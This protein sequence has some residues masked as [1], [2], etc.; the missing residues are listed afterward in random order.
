MKKIIITFLLALG[1]LYSNAQFPQPIT[2]GGSNAMTTNQGAFKSKKVLILPTIDTVHAYAQFTGALTYR[3]SNGLL[4][5]A[6]GTY[7]ELV[8]RDLIVTFP[9][10]ARGDTIVNRAAPGSVLYAGGDSNITSF[11]KFLFNSTTGLLLGRDLTLDTTVLTVNNGNSRTLTFKAYGTAG[12]AQSAGI[13]LEGGA[14]SSLNITNLTGQVRINSLDLISPSNISSLSGLNLYAN[15]TTNGFI[16]QNNYSQVSGLLL[17]IYGNGTS[18]LVIDGVTGYTG[19]GTT[20][21]QGIVDVSSTTSTI[22]IPR[23][24]KAQ[25]DAI[26]TKVAGM[27]VYQTDNTPGLRTYNGTSW[28][29]YNETAD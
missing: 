6:N 19:I 22:I 9:Q 16:L 28:I 13:Q 14:S 27:I 18:R 8:E 21:P 2:I 23:M 15:S 17:N 29:R 4:Y 1:F 25:R 12:A 10:A 7:W 24:T 3:A 5:K 11:N 26:V 20:T